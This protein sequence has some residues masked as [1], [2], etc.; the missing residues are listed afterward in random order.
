[1]AESNPLKSAMTI[2]K[3]I[4]LNLNDK[5][6]FQNSPEAKGI[7]SQLKLEQ[8]RPKLLQYLQKQIGTQ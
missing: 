8:L 4:N 7:K 6:T 5:S 1:M 3:K 2:P